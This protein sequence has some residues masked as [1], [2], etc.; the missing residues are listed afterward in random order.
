MNLPQYKYRENYNDS[1]KKRYLDFLHGLGND[2]RF[3]KD[4]WVCD[5]RIRNNS[6]PMHYSHIYFSKIPP[7]HKE[8]I[9]YFAIMRLLQGD[10]VRTVRSR[11]VGLT[12]FTKFLSESSPSRFALDCD[13]GTAV[14]FKE[15]LDK[16]KRAENTKKD[17]WLHAC[18]LLRAMDGFDDRCCR[19]PFTINP[20]GKTTKLDYK[21]IP[22]YC[23]RS[24]FVSLLPVH[25]FL[26]FFN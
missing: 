22:I 11:V 13:S 17:I 12:L 8:L 7:E 19:N 25:F 18:T 2:I 26:I 15:Y 10:T 6:D 16:S 24:C 9:K 21:C 3:D 20:Y 5:K 1:Q 14:R 23:V 4:T